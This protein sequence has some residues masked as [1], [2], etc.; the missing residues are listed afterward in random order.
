MIKISLIVFG[1]LLA[2]TVSAANPVPEIRDLDEH[3]ARMQPSCSPECVNGQ[4]ATLEGENRKAPDSFE[5]EKAWVNTHHRHGIQS[6]AEAVASAKRLFDKPDHDKSRVLSADEITAYWQSGKT[7][8]VNTAREYPPKLLSIK[9]EKG[10]NVLIDLSHQCK[11]LTLWSTAGRLH[12]MGY[13]SVTNQASL[14]T[15]LDASGVCRIRIPYDEANRVW[16]FGWY[17]NFSYNVV[18][19][20][21]GNPENPAY[22]PEE[23][24]AL[25]VFVQ[26]GGGLIVNGDLVKNS[27]EWSQN[28]LMKKFGLSFTKEKVMFEGE[29]CG[30]L[31]PGKEWEVTETAEGKPVAARREFGKGRM[32]VTGGNQLLYYDKKQNEAQQKQRDVRLNGVLDWLCADQKPVGG[33]PRLPQPMGGGGAIFPELESQNGDMV[34]YYAKNQHPALVEVATKDLHVVTDKVLGWLPSVPTK[35]PMYLILSAGGGGGWA[36]NARVPKENG[37]ISLSKTGIISIYAHE[38]A[39]TLRGP[40]GASGKIAGR[41]PFGNSGE[42]HAGWFQ[43]KVDALYNEKLLE[44][45]NKKCDI[46]SSKDFFAIDLADPEKCKTFGK[47][48]DWQKIWYI[49]QKMDD[50]Y[51]TTW[52]PCWLYV[53]HT[54]WCE[55]PDRQLTW[56]ES[57]EDMSIAVGEDL[58]PFF[59]SIGVSLKR[60]KIGQVAFEGKKLKLKPAPIKPTAPGNVRL[61]EIGDYKHVGLK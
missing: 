10:Y 4:G 46:F 18:I 47:G 3:N 45:P 50:R 36:V 20:E 15:V 14:N 35:E 44:F 11:F 9:N 61:E 7:L 31:A 37:I 41:N 12:E 1:M 17:P 33:E 34:T 51:G 19:T 52:Y 30:V 8:P 48:K 29:K 6:D 16:P 23:M 13:R 32:Y 55:S 2:F 40:V 21:Q 24:E 27:D 59:R 38:L 42:P 26:D 5:A 56:E 49:W 57:V 39:H 58:F 28:E 25:K 54:R 53:Q 60:A 22:L 43:G